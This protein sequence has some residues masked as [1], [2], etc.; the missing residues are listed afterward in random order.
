MQKIT[1]F[2]AVLAALALAA[3]A[4]AQDSVLLEVGGAPA[5]CASDAGSPFDTAE[6]CDS[7]VV[8]M[9]TFTS[10]WGNRYAI[11]P[12]VKT[13]KVSA[14]FLSNLNSASTISR[15]QATGTSY[16]SDSY[17]LWNDVNFGVNALSLAGTPVDRSMATGNQFALANAEFGT[18]DLGVE[19]SGIFGAVVNYDPSNPLRLYVTRVNAA[20]SGCDGGR[21]LGGMAL[22]VVDEAGN[23]HMRADNF[24]AG[25]ASC[26]GLTNL[27]GNNIFRVSLA[28]RACGSLNV[29]SGDYLTTGGQF[30]LG[31][32]DWL[33]RASGST[34]NTPAGVPAS[35]TGG[36]S[37][38]LASNFDIEYVRGQNFG[39]ITEDLSHLA[40]GNTNHR[41]GM[42]WHS[43]NCLSGSVMGTGAIL[44]VNASGTRSL[45]VFGVDGAGNVSAKVALDMPINVTD[46]AA[47]VVTGNNRVI[48]PVDFDH[49]HDQVAFRGGNGQVG[50]GQDQAGRLIAAAQADFPIAGGLNH[51]FNCI[52]V[53][54]HNC[55]LGTTEWT[56][57]AYN[58][59]ATSGYLGDAKAI[60]DGNGNIIGRLATL[61]QVTGGTPVGPS[62]S[63]PM[64]DSVGNVYFWAAAEFFN[65]DDP[66]NG[67]SSF[68]SALF[69]AVYDPATFSYR[70][71]RLFR[72]GWV[73]EGLNSNRQYQVR[74]VNLADGNSIDSG[75]AWS[76]NIM[77]TA[78][79][80]ADPS[81]YATS[82][83]RTLGGLVLSASI[84][85]DVDGDESFDECTG[86]G[87]GVD[88]AYRVVLF[89]SGAADAVEPVGACCDGGVCT[90]GSVADCAARQYA[91]NV[92][93]LSGAT[94]FGD[95]DGNGVVNAADRGQISANI[96]Q[97]A[98]DLVCL[99]DLDGN[100]V[101]NAADRG[102]VSAN[103]G[104][105]Q[106]L[107]DYQNG[108]GL[109]GGLPDPR[110]PAPVYQGDGSDCGSVTCN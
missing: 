18:S 1:R 75:A 66:Q 8:D 93:A 4:M 24:G 20:V 94:C 23:I 2:G 102:Q 103:I 54:R 58:S 81:G 52:L 11:A 83:S 7:Y 82:D 104:T 77:E 44:G 14:S 64:V 53:A 29:I 96:G 90:D 70:L 110:F 74:F 28:D 107:P 109:S 73:F 89:I 9:D 88:H 41:G 26:P 78:L 48:A 97:T 16:F 3:P 106:T 30:D 46:N 10:S 59:Q 101:I 60:E 50:I 36:D 92:T 5:A 32:T 80:G 85:Y 19:F 47:D 72:T 45:N 43:A 51:P 56:M 63:S 40:G 15:L 17:S 55:E 22:G 49:Y 87:T 31:A 57:A 39:A 65:P 6:Q 35:V 98:R 79:A 34:Y 71:E 69:R 42:S 68:G 12:I 25:G 21:S 33:V 105:C 100:G 84:V 62:M 91:C 67:P 27:T 76:M 99:Y 95:A 108:S 37:M 86:S 61:S 13:S 38:L